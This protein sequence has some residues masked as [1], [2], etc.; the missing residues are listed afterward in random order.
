MPKRRIADDLARI[1]AAVAAAERATAGEI[2]V[3]VADASDGYGDVRAGIAAGLT[4]C[5]V[6]AWQISGALAQRWLW[7]DLPMTASVEGPLA[8]AALAG[9]MLW[10]WTVAGRPW[11]LRRFLGHIR[12]TRAVERS[13]QAAFVV[14]GL[15]ETRDRSGVLLYVSWLEHRVQLLADLG[16]HARVGVDGWQRHVDD[17]VT[18]IRGGRPGEGLVA[19]VEAIGRDLATHF[20]PR[21]DD[22]NELP[23]EVAVD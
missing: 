15:T 14:R 12:I 6:G 20:P 17:L 23:N 1:E 7:W 8:L 18:A 5:G 21:D 13:A 4:L 10:S 9:W 3:V 22:R 19:A 11:L 2:V 16:I